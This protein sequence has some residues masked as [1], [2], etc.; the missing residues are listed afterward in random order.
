MSDDKD[1][2]LESEIAYS[3][4]EVNSDSGIGIDYLKNNRIGI[5]K[6]WNGIG[7]EVCYKK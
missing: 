5:D 4:H 7:I 2:C 3:R 6:L 1:D